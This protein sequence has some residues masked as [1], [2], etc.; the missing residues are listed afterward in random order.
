MVVQVTIQPVMD[1]VQQALG[2]SG[3]GSKGSLTGGSS[4]QGGIMDLFGGNNGSPNLGSYLQTAGGWMGNANLAAYGAGANLSSMQALDA[5]NAYRAAGDFVVDGVSYSGAN[6][7]ASLE[8]G[9]SGMFAQGQSSI[10]M[11]GSTAGAALGY[12]GAIASLA[13][14]RQPLDHRPADRGFGRMFL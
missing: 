8:S 14:G 5:A 4:Q 9:A 1:A 7:G 11:G 3:G 2:L 13:G 6:L 12:I 10:S